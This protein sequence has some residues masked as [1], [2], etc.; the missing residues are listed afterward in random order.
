MRALDAQHERDR[1]RAEADGYRQ[2]GLKLKGAPRPSRISTDTTPHYHTGLRVPASCQ[3]A[4]EGGNSD[5]HNLFPVYTDL[6]IMLK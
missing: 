4:V 6:N 2:Q 5:V 3:R 1:Y